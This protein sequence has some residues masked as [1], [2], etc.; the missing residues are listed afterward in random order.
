MIA[1]PV[2]R[3]LNALSLHTD[4]SSIWL[5]L[6]EFVDTNGIVYGLRRVNHHF[7]QQ[8]ALV[9]GGWWERQLV[10]R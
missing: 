1:R 9:D 10:Q 2:Y 8:R 5:Y 3:L 4:Y 7:H 6:C